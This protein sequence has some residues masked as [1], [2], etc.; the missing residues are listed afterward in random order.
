[1]IASKEG[2]GAA[3]DSWRDFYFLCGSS[4]AGM[5]GLMFIAVT[6]GSR[7]ITVDKLPHVETFISPSC[8]HFIHVFF[9]CCVASAPTVGPAVLGLMITITAA[10]RLVQIPKSYRL[11]KS[12]SRENLDVETSDWVLTLYLPA[13]AYALM[14][15]AG[16]SY[17]FNAAAAPNLFA[18]SLIS[19]LMIGLRGAW[20]TLI[21]L[22]TKV[23]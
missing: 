13:A 4:A 11:V 2:H 14:I 3:M 8:Y 1:M 5:T 15:G 9:L 23:D 16:L 17:L 21:W 6:F 12:A 7:L 22:A 20:E 19:L 10:W 18:A